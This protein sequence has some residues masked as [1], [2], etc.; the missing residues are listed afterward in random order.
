MATLS[1]SN[2][3]AASSAVSVVFEN[4]SYVVQV[5][6][7]QKTILDQISGVVEGG[8]L[9]ALM[10]P[11]GS[12]KSSLL[13]V[14]ARRV[15]RGVSGKIWINGKEV[16]TEE[17]RT[18]AGF[19]PQEDFLSAAMTVRENITFSAKLRLGKHMSNE[20]IRQ[21]V[22]GVITELGLEKVADS[23]VGDGSFIRG[24][25]G[26]ERKRVMIG[27]ELVTSPALLFLDEVSFFLQ[28]RNVMISNC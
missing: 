12:G 14:L 5:K 13:D 2:D 24:I 23:K 22:Q 4:L 15:R 28:H 18:I 3:P 16:S 19:V 10:G 11:S 26:G 1:P 6:K 25:S 20:E 8:Q 7:E 21:R 27:M 9:C 17:M